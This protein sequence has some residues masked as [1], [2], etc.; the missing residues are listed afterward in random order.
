MAAPNQL[1]RIA[2]VFDPG[3]GFYLV[4]VA[5]TPE[6]ASKYPN[7]PWDTKF[8][9]MGLHGPDALKYKD[10]VLVEIVQPSPSNPELIWLFQKL[11]GPVWETRMHGS[12]SL[13]PA[14]FR[15]LVETTRTE[16]EVFPDAD[17]D[18]LS[19]G[20][21]QSVVEQQK[22]TGKAVRTTTSETLG[23]SGPL[24]GFGLGDGELRTTINEDLIVTGEV[25]EPNTPTKKIVSDP[26]GNG[27]SVRK[28]VEQDVFAGEGFSSSIED[29]IPSKFRGN[30]PQTSDEITVVGN[31]EPPSLGAGE[32]SKSERQLTEFTKRVSSTYRSPDSLP[33]TLNETLV[34]ND[35]VLISR[36]QTLS[37]GDQ[38]I[39]PDALTT[40]QV[41][42]IG[43]GLTLKTEDVK[44]EVFSAASL[45]ISRPDIIPQEFRAQVPEVTTQET[46][47]GDAEL[48]TLAATDLSKSEQQLTKFT[49]RTSSSSRDATSLPSVLTESLIDGDGILVERVKTLNLGDQTVSPSATVSGQVD[50]L[51]GGLTLKIEDTKSKVFSAA[52]LSVS[53]PDIIPSEFRAELPELTSQSIVAGVVTTPQ[54]ASTDLSKSEQQ[55]TE[56]TKRTSTTSRSSTGL[57][58]T[59]TE[60]LIDNDGI[61]ITRTKTLAEGDQ[62][63]TPSATISGQV[64]AL[65]GGLTLKVEDVKS[66]IF[67]ER[68]ASHEQ[69]VNVPAKFVEKEEFESEVIESEDPS[70]PELGQGGSGVV[71]AAIQRVDAFRAST[72]KT[73]RTLAESELGGSQIF[74]NFGG[75]KAESAESLVSDSDSADEG[76]SILSSN[77]SPIG[78]GRAVKETIRAADGFPTLEGQKYD[79]DYD[80]DVPYSERVVEAGTQA[81]A[82]DIEPL[83]KWRSKIKS[84]DYDAYREKL[85]DIHVVLP[86]EESVQL[87]DVLKSVA[88]LVSRSQAVSNAYGSGN[89]FSLSTGGSVAISADLS[90]VIEDGYSGPVPAETHIFFIRQNDASAADVIKSKCNAD[91]YPRY[92]PTQKRLVMSGHGAS[93]RFQCNS[94]DDGT[95][96]SETSDMQA[97]TNV[98]TIPST[99]NELITPEIIYND[100]TATTG[101]FDVIRDNA[102][103]SWE[104]RTEDLRKLID[105]APEGTDPFLLEYLSTYVDGLENTLEIAS[106]QDIN[107]FPVQ[108]SP[109]TIPETSPT[110]VQTGRFITRSSAQLYGFGLVKITAIVAIIE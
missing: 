74:T 46:V 91:P 92:K 1:P 16:Q 32:L 51:G 31:A 108:I 63:V 6:L 66:S 87:P 49:K 107:D 29:T 70:L 22:N 5:M 8:S 84:T 43:K 24:E 105:E 52:T 95:S 73:T 77:V 103:E 89:A 58:A 82:S 69:A 18:D 76:F 41:E 17:P 21:T 59:L 101:V 4:S 27:F 60:S 13:I 80:I 42:A 34:D 110:S 61:A 19:G 102:I 36:A 53:R 64:N 109:S 83:D 56:F 54:L 3:N 72:R 96:G 71:S 68:A 99:I 45:S 47:Q 88:V 94:S 15:S 30:F 26:L 75:G 28:T 9:E 35:G 20:V 48:P 106:D 37:E 65:G 44:A 33:V 67:D 38:T 86:G 55:L 100:F 90:Y 97:F 104:K 50:A 57:P 79:A 93:Q 11:D 10:Y 62:T 7:K 85:L 78:G 98:A 12:E 40:G 14:K 2:G 23:E 81:P 25:L 39:A